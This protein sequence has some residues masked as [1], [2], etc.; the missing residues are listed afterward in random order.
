VRWN[1]AARTTTFVSANQLRAAIT[2][3]NSSST[4]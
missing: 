2:A 4:V 3:S 1:G